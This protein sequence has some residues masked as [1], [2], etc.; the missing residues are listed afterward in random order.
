MKMDFLPHARGA[1]YDHRFQ[2]RILPG[3]FKSNGTAVYNIYDKNHVLISSTSTAFNG[4]T[5]GT[6]VIFPK[7]SEALPGNFVNTN[8]AAPFTPPQRFADLTFTF[9]T[10]FA[11]VVN[12]NDMGLAHGTGLFFDPYLSVLD[13]GDQVH[14]GD[15]RMLTVPS[16]EYLW[17][18]ERVR[19]DKAYP[20]IHFIPG[21]SP[22]FTF[23]N[24]W[25]TNHN[26][27]IYDG[28]ACVLP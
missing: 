17:P 25:W 20:D 14:I 12:E 2:I 5:G 10:P 27:C 4:A 1:V 26:N 24:C 11:F 19:I 28:V 13:T 18:E 6:Y 7:T 3:V 23:P 22:D 8:E 9:D 21:P 16:T 15:L